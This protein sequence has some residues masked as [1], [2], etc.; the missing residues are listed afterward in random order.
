MRE[1]SASV[2][3]ACPAEAAFDFVADH[4]NVPKVL[5]G[6]TRWEPLGRRRSGEGARYS[7]E[8]RTLGIPMANVLV[9]DR[10]Q[11]PRAIGWHSESGLIEQIGGWRF[12]AMGRDRV[13]VTLTIGYQ[14]PGSALGNLL[15]GR[16]DGVVRR[17]LE[18]ALEAMRELLEVGPE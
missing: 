14:P 15:A 2:R 10:W 13:E 6:I 16:V 3:I 5:D 4:R 18:R 7:V 11:R 8:M 1:F 9:I 17:R 12:L